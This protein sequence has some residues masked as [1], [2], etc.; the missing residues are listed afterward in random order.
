[1]IAQSPSWYMYL[2]WNHSIS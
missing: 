2:M 1:M